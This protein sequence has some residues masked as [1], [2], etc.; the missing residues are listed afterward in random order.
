M[1]GVF[2]QCGDR[3]ETGSNPHVLQDDLTQRY[4]GA[5]RRQL[6]HFDQVATID[7]AGVDLAQVIGCQKIHATR[8]VH[9]WA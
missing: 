8:A 1:S 6:I 4:V 5:W 9:Q 3:Y 7:D 2:L